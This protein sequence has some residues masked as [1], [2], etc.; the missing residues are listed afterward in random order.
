MIG[1]INN[2]YPIDFL[3]FILT[4]L[5]LRRYRNKNKYFFKENYNH[6]PL[7]NKQINNFKRF[8]SAS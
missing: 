6:Q 5:S 2:F 1:K 8:L 3:N 4:G 7:K